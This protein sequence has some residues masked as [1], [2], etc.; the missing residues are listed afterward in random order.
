MSCNR[1][2][3]QVEQQY[4]EAMGLD[5]G[6]FFC[7]LSGEC[8]LLHWKWRE[9]VTLFGA[10]PER[11][12]LLNAVAGSFFWI[13]QDS[14][15]ENILLHIAR[16]TDKEKV[17]GKDNLTL[18]RLPAKVDTTIRADVDG[19]LSTCTQKCEFAIDWRNRYIAHRDLGLALNVEAKPLAQAS[20]QAVNEAIGSI[21]ALLNEVQLHYLDSS[22]AYGFIISHRS[23][24]ALLCVLRDGLK[25]EERRQQRLRS[26]NYEP[27]D[28]DSPPAL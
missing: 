25:A 27:E 28:L 22:V 15:W 10:K 5:L 19:L 14:L 12:D 2:A 9:Y 24:E 4:I 17:A 11:I 21:S 1:T 13:L 6:R 16:L 3:E 20:R 7:R 23:A 26:G 18:L 8:Q